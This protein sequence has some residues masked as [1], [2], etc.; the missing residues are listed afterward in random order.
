MSFDQ[1]ASA[2][3]IIFLCFVICNTLIKQ[4]LTV[5]NLHMHFIFM[6]V[7][8]IILQLQN[9]TDNIKFLLHVCVGSMLLVSS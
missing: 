3:D 8:K 4:S 2:N 1:L 5:S 7:S 9:V 6:R